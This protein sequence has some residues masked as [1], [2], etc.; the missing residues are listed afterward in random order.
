MTSQKP[1]KHLLSYNYFSMIDFTSVNHDM[2]DNAIDI[3]KKLQ[4]QYL[5]SVILKKSRA[6]FANDWLVNPLLI[7]FTKMANL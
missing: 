2:N 4:D 5:Q 3:K 1:L 6:F 7:I